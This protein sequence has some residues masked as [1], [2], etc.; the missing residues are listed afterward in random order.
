MKKNTYET[1]K[2]ETVSAASIL[3]NLG[4]AIAIYGPN[5]EA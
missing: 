1:P 2:L 3:A 4:P 5:N